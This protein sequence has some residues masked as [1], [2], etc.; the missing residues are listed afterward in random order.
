LAQKLA[1]KLGAVVLPTILFKMMKS[2]LKDPVFDIRVGDARRLLYM[3][4][5]TTIYLLFR[6]HLRYY[7]ATLVYW[8]AVGKLILMQKRTQPFLS[9]KSAL[10][11]YRR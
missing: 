3:W 5:D 11:P 2:Y 6:Q 9:G 7:L 8:C 10:H 4:D 1:N